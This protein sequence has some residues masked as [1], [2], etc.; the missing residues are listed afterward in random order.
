MKAIFLSDA[1]LRGPG[2]AAHKKLIRF[3]DLLRGRGHIDVRQGPDD[4]L[5]IDHL[6]IAGDFFDFWFGRGDVIYPAFRHM[7]ERIAA[8]KLEG[9]RISICEGNHDYYLGEY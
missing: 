7:V 4:P 1:H 5:I 8:L 3:F 6:V 9:V 2:D